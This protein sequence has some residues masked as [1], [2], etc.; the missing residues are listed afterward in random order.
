MVISIRP[1]HPNDYEMICSWFKH[2]GDAQPTPGMLLEDGTFIMEIDYFPAICQTVLLTQSKDMAY[3]EFLIKNP[4]FTAS[5]EDYISVL[6]DRCFRYAS[7][8]GYSRILT[9]SEN[10]KLSEK[11]KRLGMTET[12]K[13][14]GLIKELPCR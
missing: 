3:L 8:R 9:F 5:L 1:Y 2:F 12:C 14:T 4:E 10:D 11:F 13:V 6:W 7:E